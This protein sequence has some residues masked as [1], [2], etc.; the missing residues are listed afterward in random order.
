MWWALNGT[1]PLGTF[2]QSW[3]ADTAH[4]CVPVNTGQWGHVLFYAIEC[5]SVL[6]CVCVFV[7]VCV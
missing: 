2:L 1:V 5:A 3:N 4:K 6:V 7:C